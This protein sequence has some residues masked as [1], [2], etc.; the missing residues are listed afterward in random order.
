M[1][2]TIQLSD[3][4]FGAHVSSLSSAKDRLS[5]VSPTKADMTSESK[6]LDLY[7]Q[8]FHELQALIRSYV[9]LLEADISLIQET[10]QELIRT[11]HTLGQS[12]FSG[13]N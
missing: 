2:G 8:Q 9:T 13:L 3:V 1:Y 4:I 12:L 11:D 5:S 7:E 6:V 10:G